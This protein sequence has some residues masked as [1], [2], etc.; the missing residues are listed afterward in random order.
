MDGKI[1]DFI[2]TIRERLDTRKA[3]LYGEV[4]KLEKKP[5]V[6]RGRDSSLH[7]DTAVGFI[8]EFWR[9]AKMKG[10]ER[11]NNPSK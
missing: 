11:V 8:A 9:E 5:S 6:H 4:W 10:G 1:Y 2:N 7:G 3:R